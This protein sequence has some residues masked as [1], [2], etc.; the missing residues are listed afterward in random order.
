MVALVRDPRLR[1][2]PLR[3]AYLGLPVGALLLLG[4]GHE[5]VVAT[6]APRG[7]PGSRR[8]E[9]RLGSPLLGPQTLAADV[10]GAMESGRAELLVSYFWPRLIPMSLLEAV[11]LGG[12]GVHPSLLPRHRGP[13]PTAWAI[14][15]GDAETG[16]SVHRLSAEFD[17]GVVLAQ[18]ATPI[19]PEENA[20]QLSRRLDRLALPAL[21]EVVG[22]VARGE[23]LL[24]QLQD[25]RLATA[26]PIMDEALCSADFTM[27]PRA[28]ARRVRA[29]TPSPGVWMRVGDTDVCLVRVRVGDDAPRVMGELAPGSAVFSRGRV[30]LRTGAGVIEVLQVETERSGLTAPMSLADLGKL[31]CQ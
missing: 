20:W 7:A 25:E 22:R 17:T 19:R 23:P 18:R 14:D 24:E 9:R 29:L 2:K 27:D 26:A 28:F 15:A 3:I 6:C 1:G 11:P 13:D 16:V 5:V 8:L 30:W 10:R 31:L 21:R 12:I 4:D